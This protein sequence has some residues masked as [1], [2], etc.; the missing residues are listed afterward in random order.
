MRLITTTILVLTINVV[1]A[2]TDVE[3][4]KQDVDN[5]LQQDKPLEAL[6]IMEGLVNRQDTISGYGRYKTRIGL[7]YQSLDS[8][9][10]AR[11]WYLSV[12]NDSLITDSVEDFWL[13]DWEVRGNYKHVSCYQIAVSY[14]KENDFNK[15]IEF[16]KLAL[17]SFPYYHFSGSD[18]NKNRVRICNNI[19]D[20]YSKQGDLTTAFS[21]LLPFFFFFI[22][23]SNLPRY[24]TSLIFK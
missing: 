13:G 22:I 17:D 11:K 7:I 19:A 23:Y 1:L 21:Y 2:Q 10:Q 24:K 20:L 6:A 9:E 15:S 5:L 16:Y 8:I 12:M 18:I 4:L 14:Y 3:N